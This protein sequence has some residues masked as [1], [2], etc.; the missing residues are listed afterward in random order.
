VLIL[1]DVK[2]FCFDT[3]LQVLIL[4]DLRW[5]KIAANRR[6]F[7]AQGAGDWAETKT[8]Q[9]Q[10]RAAANSSRHTSQRARMY[11]N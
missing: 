11:N 10:K 5:T 4:K 8:R 6:L 3:L 1:K 9:A 2:V 7:G